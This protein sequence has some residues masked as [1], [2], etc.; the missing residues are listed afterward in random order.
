M[1][2]Q[3][4]W[5]LQS[6]YGT[7][8]GWVCGSFWLLQGPDQTIKWRYNKSPMSYLRAQMEHSYPMPGTY[9]AFILYSLGWCSPD[10]RLS[11]F[12]LFFSILIAFTPQ[13]IDVCGSFF[14]V[15][16][17][18]WHFSSASLESPSQWPIPASPLPHPPPPSCGHY[19]LLY[20]MA[21]R[22]SRRL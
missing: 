4:Y 10:Q 5:P 14:K 18:T 15:S 2:E 12:V 11:C 6:H 16:H 1:P 20:I 13:A 9:A 7:I 17:N 21:N 19:H 22:F 3:W 8:F